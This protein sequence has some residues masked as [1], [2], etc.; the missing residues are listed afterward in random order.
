MSL[1]HPVVG[2]DVKE[3]SGEEVQRVLRRHGDVAEV[4]VPKKTLETLSR[5]NHVADGD[6]DAVI[7]RT[8]RSEIEAKSFFVTFKI[9]ILTPYRLVMR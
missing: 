1:S 8:K 4:D 5:R 3:G 9:K 2:E 7:G 6:R